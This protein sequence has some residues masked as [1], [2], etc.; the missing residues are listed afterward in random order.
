MLGLTAT[1]GACIDYMSP[2]MFFFFI[3][4]KKK[5]RKKKLFS[6]VLKTLIKLAR[7]YKRLLCGQL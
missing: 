1:E 6:L 4:R 7:H 2:S 5:K 3:L